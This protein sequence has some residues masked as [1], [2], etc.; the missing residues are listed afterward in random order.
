[1]QVTGQFTIS[2]QINGTT[3]VSVIPSGKTTIEGPD[4]TRCSS[5]VRVSFY[6]FGGTPPYRVSLNFPDAASL[7]TTVV[8]TQGGSFD[9]VTNG[10]CFTG[11]QPVIVDASGLTVSNAPTVDNKFGT[12]DPTVT[13][14]LVVSPGAYGSSTSPVSCAG[15]TFNFTI[16]GKSPFSASSSRPVVFGSNPV[17]TSPG[18]LS[19]SSVPTGGLT[20]ITIGDANSPQQLAIAQIYCQ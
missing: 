15:A 19:V 4:K 2:Q 13:V 3:V 9:I 16:T 1:M 5:G 14:P 17:S 20:T 12:L 10:S 11:L 6:I 18:T 8:N 7:S